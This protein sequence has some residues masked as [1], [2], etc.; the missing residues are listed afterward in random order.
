M[1]KKSLWKLILILAI[2]CIIGFMPAPAGL[3]ELTWVLFGI[4]LAAIVGLVIKPFPE[5]VVLLIAVAASMVVVG[6]LSDGAFKTTAVL[7]GYSSGTT[8]LVFSAFTLSAAFVTTGLGKR[9]AYLLIGKI[10]NTT[11]GLG[12]VTVFLD[13]VLAPATPSNTARAGG[14]VLPIIN[15]VAVALGSE[16][17]KSPRRVGHYLMM[18]IYMVTKTTSYMFFT[19]MAGNI[20]AL[21]MINDIL[22]LQISW[23]G[24][25]LAAGLPGI[26]MLLV[27]PLVI[28]TMYPP[29]I[30]KVD[31]K[32]IAKAGLA[33]LGPMKIREKMLL[34]VFVLAL[35][36]IVTWEDVV[37]NKGGWNTLIWYG[38]IIGLS[39]LLSKVKFFE[40]LAE[41][42]KNNLAFDGHGNVAFFVIIFLSIIVR[43]FF[44]SGSAYIVAMLPVFAML[45][46]VSGAPLM[47]TALAL[48]FSNS[49]GGMVTHYGGAA[50]PVIFG[51]GY[52]DIKSWW[53]VGAVLTI[54]TFLVHIT[55][56]VWWWNMLIGWNML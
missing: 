12:Y 26:I 21:K 42:F 48:L 24:W 32:T 30:K 31:N 27:T 19:A 46:N 45:A 10:G 15:S 29:E 40:W 13:L 34:G 25:A 5:P 35:L 43:Y 14:I 49:Y 37:K 47:L 56:G 18:S 44:A 53:L 3:S 20:L 7:S 41:V 4:Y 52:N 55:L 54:L 50:G 36:G 9:I 23:G 11:L 39:S 17:E 38:G 28:Y 8:W 6:N 33:E 2:P 1:N 16:P 22:H 51:V